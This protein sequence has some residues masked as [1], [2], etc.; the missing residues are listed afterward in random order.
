MKLKKLIIENFR[1][2]SGS[3][4]FNF[5]NKSLIILDGPNGHGKS[6]FF[7][8][9]QWCLTGEIQRYKGSNEHYNFNYIINNEAFQNLPVTMKV[10]A[11]LGSENNTDL[12]KITRV[13]R[14]TKKST[15]NKIII[16]N[17]EFSLREGKE[18]IKDILVNKHWIESTTDNLGNAADIDFARFF[19][20]TQLLSQDELRD[21][22]Q[23][24]NPKDRFHVL[25]NLLGLKKYGGHFTTYLNEVIDVLKGKSNENEK[26]LNNLQKEHLK[27][28]TKLQT[29]A[30]LMNNVGNLSEQQIINNLMNNPKL[31]SLKLHPINEINKESQSSLIEIRNNINTEK[32]F[33]ENNILNLKNGLTDLKTLP[34]H[35]EEKKTNLNIQLLQL[36]HK[37]TNRLSGINNCKNKIADLNIVKQKQ[38]EFQNIANTIQSLLQEKNE[39]KVENEQILNH[40]LLLNLKKANID[41]AEFNSEYHQKQVHSKYL[42]TLQ[43]IR[44]SE[45]DLILL[46][47]QL[48]SYRI[49]KQESELNSTSI[50]KE[51]LSLNDVLDKIAKERESNTSDRI[52]QLVYEVQQHLLDSQSCT[53]CMVCGNEFDNVGELHKRLLYQINESEKLRTKI[54]QKYIKHSTEKKILEEKLSKIKEDLENIS[55]K[56]MEVETKINQ[57]YIHIEKL[58][59][60]ILDNSI[61]SIST[62]AL[63]KEL[64]RT[65]AFLNTHR[66]TNSLI[67]NLQKNIEKG[68]ILNNDIS[69]HKKKLTNINTS[70]GKHTGYLNNNSN[71]LQS[72][73]DFLQNYELKALQHLNNLTQQIKTCE[74]ELQQIG[75][76]INARQNKIKQLNKII[77]NF[78]GDLEFLEQSI[79]K[80]EKKY[81][82]LT[83]SDQ[84]LQ[85]ILE[86]IQVFLSQENLLLLRSKENVLQEDLNKYKKKKELY[87]QLN[88]DIL[89][90]KKNHTTVQSTLMTNYLSSYSDIIDQLFMQISPHAIFRHVHL[91]TED[92]NL[93]IIMSKK[94]SKDENLSKL[95]SRELA[96]RFN[97]SLTFSSG[98]ASVLAVC[99]FL[100]LNQGQNWTKLQLLGIDDP[101]QNMDDVNTFSF[102]DV[103]SQLS[104]EK[105][106]FI[107][108]HSKEFTALMRAKV[109]VPDD[110]IGYINF[111]SYSGNNID[112]E[113]NCSL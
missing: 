69:N 25:E 42:L 55:N 98:Q 89:E 16:N 70:L 85:Q 54:D 72:K 76:D 37:Q 24:T 57:L 64:E 48:Y 8:A 21:F 109:G 74:I 100:A 32:Q 38:V 111:Q 47:K 63:P 97:A 13:L 3:H 31:K 65:E 91:V 18:M 11:W 77:P 30:E 5:E 104:L 51:S 62:E 14:K 19:S 20:A 10:E 50:E 113:T 78:N 27:I 67:E 59:I 15:S 45:E 60:S 4:E 105:Q 73:I 41:F 107:S 92:G 87:E 90:S 88:T 68:K 40:A 103:L 33:C 94:S 75:H 43:E 2:F 112:F 99:I 35:S 95:S 26:L 6:S 110:K 101:F 82:D 79:N 9:I 52:N 46:Q 1:I 81:T 86:N 96:A 58:K 36:K 29:Q 44:K 7:D 39:L 66:I 93:Y 28:T 34:N 53:N 17:K 49:K 106:I 61:F 80:Y 84:T 12:T 108:T 71:K 23:N 102:I 22:I 83:D 56:I